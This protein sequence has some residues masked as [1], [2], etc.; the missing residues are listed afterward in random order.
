MLVLINVKYGF[1][2]GMHNLAVPTR[3]KSWLLSQGC[4]ASNHP[5]VLPAH[6]KCPVS[7]HPLQLAPAKL[8]SNV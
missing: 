6:S 4:A 7:P 1:T 2:A 5:I 8:K 3:L